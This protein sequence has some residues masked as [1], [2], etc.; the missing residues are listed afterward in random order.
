MEPNI[1]TQFGPLLLLVGVM[2][3]FFIRPQAKKQKQQ[4]QFVNQ[5]EKG[6]DVVTTSGMLGRIVKIEDDIVTLELEPKTFVRIT[7][8][9]ISRELT[10]SVFPNS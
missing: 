5:L 4:Q 1:L 6:K 2:Y 10:D 8:G 3:F 9:S 7:R